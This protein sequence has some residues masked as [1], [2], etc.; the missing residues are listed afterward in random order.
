MMKKGKWEYVEVLK[1]GATKVHATKDA[2]LASIKHREAGEKASVRA[3]ASRIHAGAMMGERSEDAKFD[4]LG[5]AIH[6]HH[7]ITKRR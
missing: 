4:R 2:Y 5:D 7:V 1:N 6:R 3:G